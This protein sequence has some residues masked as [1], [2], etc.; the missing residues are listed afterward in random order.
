MTARARVRRVRSVSEVD[1]WL[2]A[3]LADPQLTEDARDVARVIAAGIVAGSGEFTTDCGTF[4][5]VDRA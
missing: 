4:R 2:A 1:A 5:A 3:V